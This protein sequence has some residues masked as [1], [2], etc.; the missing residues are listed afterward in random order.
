MP[1]SLISLLLILLQNRLPLTNHIEKR[2]VH[3]A[4]LAHSLYVWVEG[5]EGRKEALTRAMRATTAATKR[6]DV[7]AIVKI[8]WR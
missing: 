6:V 8:K 1:A 3:H 7:R 2:G 5:W 4:C